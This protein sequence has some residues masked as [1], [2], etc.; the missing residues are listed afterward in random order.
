MMWRTAILFLVFVIDLFVFAGAEKSWFDVFAFAVT[1]IIV[2]ALIAFWAVPR[3]WGRRD[4][5]SPA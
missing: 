3:D 2:V 5:S 4:P 1:T